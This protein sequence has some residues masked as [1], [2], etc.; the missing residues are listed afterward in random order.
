MVRTDFDH[1]RNLIMGGIDRSAKS[2]NRETDMAQMIDFIAEMHSEA[3]VILADMVLT[4]AKMTEKKEMVP[5][6]VRLVRN[7]IEA[8]DSDFTL[9]VR[10]KLLQRIA[11][12]G[13]PDPY[14]VTPD[15]PPAGH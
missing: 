5:E 2:E 1:L 11:E 15:K 3:V 4:S 13:L 6:M 10:R 8:S 9:R 14:E 7:M 12:G